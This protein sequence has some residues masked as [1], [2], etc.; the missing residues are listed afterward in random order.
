MLAL[1]YRTDR[2]FGCGFQSRD[3]VIQHFDVI[4][5]PSGGTIADGFLLWR[6]RIKKRGLGSMHLD[7]ESFDV[8]RRPIRRQNRFFG[9][10][11]PRKTYGAAGSK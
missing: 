11:Q 5:D 4:G 10:H 7:V 2:I 8:E 1:A 6:T 3:I 9:G